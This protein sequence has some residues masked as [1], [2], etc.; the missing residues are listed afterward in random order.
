MDKPF[1]KS[2]EDI[3]GKFP[4]DNHESRTPRGE[5]A[6]INIAAEAGSG[7]GNDG[8]FAANSHV[9]PE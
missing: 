7:C 8:C 5:T 1:K 2:H 9:L 3:G 4:L 6:E